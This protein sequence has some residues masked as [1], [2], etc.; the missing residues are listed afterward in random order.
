VREAY[1][2]LSGVVGIVLNLLLGGAKLAIGFF[3]GS[4]AV[5]ADAINNLTDAASSVATLIG[6]KLAARSSD[7]SHPFGHARIEYMT[8]VIISAMVILV[9]LRLVTTS[10][11]KILTPEHVTVNL[12]ILCFLAALIAVKIW[13]WRFNLNLAEKIESSALKATGIDSR[14]DVVATTVVLLSMLVDHL[15]GW[16]LDGYVGIGVAV[17]IVIS[18]LKLVK[19]TT[20]PLLGQPPDPKF[21]KTLTNF[22]LERK[23]VMGLHDL[24]VHDYGPGH[25][26]ATVHIEVDAYEDVMR[27]HELL[28][29]IERD[30]KTRLGIELVGHMD[31][32]DTKD[33]LVFDLREAMTR[34]LLH[35]DGVRGIHDLRIVRGPTRTNVIFDVV[36][37]RRR[38]A[39]REAEITEII[40]AA[41]AG[42]DPS[43]R[44]VL[45][46]DMDYTAESFDAAFRKEE[47]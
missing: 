2:L 5:M 9:G 18:G 19:E 37:S 20:A 26:F 16:T 45:T 3:S 30:A 11:D 25:I 33:Q 24:V 34:T 47:R 8:G 7:E 15:T 17:F 32:I 41:L 27:S 6:F 36:L 43:L 13:L 38:D 40:R 31:P 28:D 44:P 22:I 1:G 29:D 12:P 39:T 21:V 10:F 46:Y 4:V 42:I 35:V 14:N 23:G